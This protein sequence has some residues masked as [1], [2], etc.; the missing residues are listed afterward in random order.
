MAIKCGGEG[1]QAALSCG[2]DVRIHF[3]KEEL[4]VEQKFWLREQRP[5][6]PGSVGL[7]WQTRTSAIRKLSRFPAA[8]NSRSKSKS[9]HRLLRNVSTAKLC[10]DSIVNSRS[11]EPRD[12]L[13]LLAN[14]IEPILASY[15]A[16]GEST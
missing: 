12:S 2:F 13:C 15:T 11:A 10:A 1:T 7:A 16:I 9:I 6:G 14:G 4:V 8:S 3:V 5:I